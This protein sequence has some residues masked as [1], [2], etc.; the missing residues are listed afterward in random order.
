MLTND[1]KVQGYL[2]R[3]LCASAAQWSVRCD[4]RVNSL[5]AII[6]NGFTLQFGDIKSVGALKCSK[7]IKQAA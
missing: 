2:K 4:Q 3:N 7:L 1:I 5:Y 6:K